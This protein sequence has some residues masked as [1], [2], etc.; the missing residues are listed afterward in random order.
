MGHGPQEHYLCVY[1]HNFFVRIY[2]L[3]CMYI[4]V[5]SM[6]WC[7]YTGAYVLSADVLGRL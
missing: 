1:K 3:V 2:V 6:Y 7:A 5:Y 4:D